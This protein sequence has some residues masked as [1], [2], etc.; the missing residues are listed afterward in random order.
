MLNAKNSSKFTKNSKI[1]IGL[2]AILAILYVLSFTKSCTSTDKREK[3]KTALV[4]QKYKDSI[5]SIILQDATGT[6]VLKNIGSF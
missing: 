3:V 5:E 6:L 4:N 1:L 2:A